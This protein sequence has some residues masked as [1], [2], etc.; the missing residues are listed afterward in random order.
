MPAPQEQPPASVPATASDATPLG[1]PAP[2]RR[3]SVRAT[4]IAWCTTLILLATAVVLFALQANKEAPLPVTAPRTLANV[5][6]LRIAPCEHRESLV[7]PAR[8]EADH[9]AIISS[10]L[11]GRLAEWLA[12]E[13][14]HVQAGQVVAT[15][16]SD[17]QKALQARLQA[18]LESAKCAATVSN[19]QVVTARLTAEKAELDAG[20]LKLEL[21]SAKAQLDLAK[22]SHARV[23]TLSESQ[24][25][26][27]AEVDTAQHA[28]IQAKLQVDRA[29]DAISR[30]E[31]TVATAKAQIVA[32]EATAELGD[33]RIQEVERQLSSVSVTLSKRQLRAPFAGRL[34][35]HL[36]EVGEVVASG[37]PLAR[38]YDLVH[39]RA[40]V[41]VA[42]RYVPFLDTSNP[43]V[44]EYV[45]LAMP[46][47][48]PAIRSRL[49]IPG[50]PKL[51]G[52]AHSGVELD[53]KIE[54]ISQASDAASNTFQLELRLINPGE[55]LKQGMIAQAHIDYLLYRAAIVIPLRAILVADV[56]PRV[57][58]VEEQNGGD[59]AQVRDIQPISINGEDVLV[60]GGVDAGDRVIV[61]G[62]KGV[63]NGEQVNVIMSD[64]VVQMD[65]VPPEPS[66]SDPPESPPIRVPADY[67]ATKDTAEGGE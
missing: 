7:L 61:A 44:G 18:E 43:A 17:D 38:L 28:L 23:Q 8:I 62:G 36:V 63:M 55:A 57:L 47:A 42:D 13:G 49:I 59:V 5:E 58:V 67:K 10:E 51:T 35:E 15:L 66:D 65:D 39:V 56:G 29:N 21:S 50:L 14:D 30:A 34:E 20:S 24:I 6:V 37:A 2:R 11:P 45:A 52:G 22:R 41:D 9:Q 40:I 12:G 54:R 53:A 27:E 31:V 64:G 4:V 48:E 33:A 1:H 32:A 3:R 60:S 46:G 19:S 25:T 26:S 16:N